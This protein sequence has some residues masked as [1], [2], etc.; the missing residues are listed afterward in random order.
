MYSLN[1]A[2]G[3]VIRLSDGHQV[4]PAQSIE[5]PDYQ[6][7]IAW[8]NAG[9]TPA[10]EYAPPLIP[11]QPKIKVGAFRERIGETVKLKIEMACLDNPAAA[12]EQRLLAAKL[13]VMKDDLANYTH[14][15]LSR[16][17]VLASL[18]Q[19]KGAGIMTQ[20]DI[21]RIY[22]PPFREDELYHG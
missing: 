7:Y 12:T 11:A 18:N 14:V 21:D 19:L 10:L 1:T 20:A 5:D 9:N 17:D 3:I 2:T 13:R 8:V 6:A 15:D 4:A 22:A 16:P